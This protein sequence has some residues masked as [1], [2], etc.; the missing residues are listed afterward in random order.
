MLLFIEMLDTGLFLFNTA[1]STFLLVKSVKY[2][3]LFV[4]LTALPLLVK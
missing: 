3:I 4:W 2:A 1:I